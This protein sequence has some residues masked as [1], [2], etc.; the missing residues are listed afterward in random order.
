MKVTR[1]EEQKTVPYSEVDCGDVFESVDDLGT[2][3][4]CADY[5]DRDGDHINIDVEDGSIAYFSD[6]DRV[7]IRDAELIVN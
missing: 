2:L 6:T 4:L 1:K 3:Y 7:I 5:Q